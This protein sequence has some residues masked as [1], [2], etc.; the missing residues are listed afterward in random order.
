[1]NIHG[2][3]ISSYRSQRGYS[4]IELMIS[5]TIGLLIM[6]AV[7]TMY[8]SIVKSDRDNLKAIRLNQDLRAAMGLIVRDLRR[9]EYN[10]GAAAI[11]LGGTASPFTNFTHVPAN[12]CF[13][14]SYDENKDGVSAGESFGFRLNVNGLDGAIQSSTNTTDCT[15]GTWFPLTDEFLTNISAFTFIDTPSIV[16]LD[17][18]SPGPPV[19]PEKSITTHQITITITANLIKDPTVIRTITETVEVRNV[20]VKL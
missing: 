5:I 16:I 7:L 14:Y 19:I 4:L 15:D 20:E 3:R 1:M 9:A 6:A 2:L 13:H 10:F 8:V 12:S 17:P 11:I 18:G